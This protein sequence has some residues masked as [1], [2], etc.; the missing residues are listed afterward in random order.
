LG[1]KICFAC[2][3]TSDGGRFIL[4]DGMVTF[5]MAGSLPQ[6]WSLRVSTTFDPDTELTN[7]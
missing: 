3:H 2:L 4:D 5:L 1:I 7:L 6:Y